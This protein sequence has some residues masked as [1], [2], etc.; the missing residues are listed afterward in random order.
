M[1]PLGK[2]ATLMNTAGDFSD[3]TFWHSS[4]SWHILLTKTKTWVPN[5]FFYN[6]RPDIDLH[7]CHFGLVG[8]AICI[9]RRLTAEC[10]QHKCATLLLWQLRKSALSRRLTGPEQKWWSTIKLC[11]MITRGLWNI[12]SGLIITLT[13]IST[14]CEAKRWHR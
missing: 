14:S 6:Y 10:D 2:T 3:G 13:Y 7:D 4:N 9:Q 11:Q 8:M 5:I 1:Y 12:F